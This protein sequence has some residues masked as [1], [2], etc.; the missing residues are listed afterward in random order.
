MNPVSTDMNHSASRAEKICFSLF[1]VF[2][3]K[4]KIEFTK[5]KKEK[6]NMFSIYL[7]CY[8]IPWGGWILKK[9]I[10]V[11]GIELKKNEPT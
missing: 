9:C 10:P 6:T 2:D 3:A 1:R 8:S 5:K 11:F 4:N 7:I